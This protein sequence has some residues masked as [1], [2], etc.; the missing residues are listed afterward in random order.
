MTHRRFL[1]TL[2]LLFLLCSSSFLAAR[3]EMEIHFIDVGQGDSIL[4]LT[5]NDKSILI[6]GGPS[7]A[8]ARI[9]RYLNQLG[10]HSL[11]LVVISHTHAD[12]IGGLRAL[13]KAIPVR[14]LLDS[15]FAN[16][17]PAYEDILSYVKAHNIEYI[18]ARSGKRIDIDKTRKIA[19]E[20]LAPPKENFLSGT[21]SDV[22]ANSVVLKI[23]YNTIS[24]LF[25]GDS[26]EPSEEFLLGQKK[27]LLPATLLKVAHH[28][29][30][31]SSTNAFLSA[32]HPK[33]AIVSCGR[34][35]SF[36]HPNPEA[37]ARLSA[38]GAT[39]YRTD[40]AG[41]VIFS[42]NGTKY[43]VRQF[44]MSHLGQ[45]ASP[46]SAKFVAKIGGQKYHKNPCFHLKK[47]NPEEYM[48][49][50]SAEEAKAWG[51]TPANCSE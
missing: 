46:E 20:V 48:F 4:I 25:P 35:N 40:Q 30:R 43:H 13:I 5:P 27:D 18:L 21:R 7:S 45:M 38:V 49:F 12:H 39:I 19:I 24:A 15:G 1:L 16:P 51:L 50:N 23:N 28:G 36:K 29:S 42:T 8:S 41:T 44:D 33:V 9:Q 10:L 17:S 34:H 3:E 6:D 47:V 22:N 37:L 26:E 11:D 32:V 14:K 2:T 31:Y